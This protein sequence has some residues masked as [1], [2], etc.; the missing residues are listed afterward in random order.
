MS[1]SF[2][3]ASGLGLGVKDGVGNV[4]CEVLDANVRGRSASDVG[5]CRI[6]RGDDEVTISSGESD[7]N[8]E[9]SKSMSL[10]EDGASSLRS[11]IEPSDD[12]GKSDNFW[13]VQVIEKSVSAF[14]SSS[15]SST[16]R[17]V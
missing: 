5:R 11:E 14:S 17:S 16:S 10:T 15:S 13:G 8:E 12:D 4:V 3:S 9:S 2:L 1:D 7:E 6:G